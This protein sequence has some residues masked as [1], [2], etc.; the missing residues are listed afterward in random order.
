M[1]AV[2][3]S[4]K[5]CCKC[6]HF[7]SCIVKKF[8]E[9]FPTQGQ[10]N[11]SI[12]LYSLTDPPNVCLPKRWIVS[13]IGKSLITVILDPVIWDQSRFLGTCLTPARV[14]SRVWEVRASGKG[15]V[16]TWPVTR[17]HPAG[18]VRVSSKEGV[19]GYIPSILIS[20]WLLPPG[21]VLTSLSRR[22]WT[23][24][25]GEMWSTLTF[26]WTSTWRIWWRTL[27]RPGCWACWHLYPNSLW[28]CHWEA[29]FMKTF[30]S[31]VSSRHLPLLHSTE[32]V[33]HRYDFGHSV[34]PWSSGFVQGHFSLPV[35]YFH[36]WNLCLFQYYFLWYLCIPALALPVSTTRSPRS[37]TADYRLVLRTG[38]IHAPGK[39]QE[40]NG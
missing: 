6:P 38:K 15:W 20:I 32:C 25:P 33:H 9:L 29:D 11:H 30:H 14:R 24:W 18:L 16:G 1:V 35:G 12:P 39:M 13:C 2:H 31:V 21:M 40:K 34:G 22:A 36:R 26:R 28:S 4:T 19:G 10:R 23:T 17:L 5:I 27:P 3:D 7:N 37:F 8:L